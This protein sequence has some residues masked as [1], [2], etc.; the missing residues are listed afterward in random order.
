MALEGVRRED[1]QTEVDMYHTR[2]SRR[3]LV[4]R[5][6]LAVP[7]QHVARVPAILVAQ[8]R[9][10]AGSAASRKSRLH[11]GE[12]AGQIRIAVQNEK[13]LTEKRQRV[14]QRTAG[15]QRARSV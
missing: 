10:Q 12:R 1:T 6:D 2:R 15:S 5:D 14:S 3:P 13:S 7:E 9:D 4:V 8:Y 11:G